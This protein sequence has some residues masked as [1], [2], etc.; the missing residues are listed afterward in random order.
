M[1][2][3]GLPTESTSLAGQ[4]QSEYSLSASISCTSGNHPPMIETSQHKHEK[5]ATAGKQAVIAAAAA[6]E[7]SKSKYHTTS[8]IQ[9]STSRGMSKAGHSTEDDSSGAGKTGYS[10]SRTK[11]KRKTATRKRQHGELRWV[12]SWWGVSGKTGQGR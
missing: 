8:N 6:V 9:L 5:G 11:R 3:E 2:T 12:C 10:S 4:S 1:T 7:S